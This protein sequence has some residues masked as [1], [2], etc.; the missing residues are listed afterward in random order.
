MNTEPEEAVSYEGS[1][2][3]AGG[4]LRGIAASGAKRGQE[5]LGEHDGVGGEQTGGAAHAASPQALAALERRLRE[6]SRED[7]AAPGLGHPVDSTSVP[8]VAQRLEAEARDARHRVQ[9]RGPP[10]V[11][12]DRLAAKLRVPGEGANPHAGGCDARAARDERSEVYP[13]QG[14][15]FAPGQA[16]G[17]DDACRAERAVSRSENAEA[18]AELGRWVGRGV[19]VNGGGGLVLALHEPG[20]G[21]GTVEQVNANGRLPY[22]NVRIKILGGGRRYPGM[23]RSFV[24]GEKQA[25]CADSMLRA[26]HE[27]TAKLAR[28]LGRE[29]KKLHKENM[30]VETETLRLE[31]RW[32]PRFDSEVRSHVKQARLDIDSAIFGK[33]AQL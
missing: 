22:A 31:E 5:L 29:V 17:Q 1:V 21:V 8:G 3:G 9:G 23:K 19:E 26:V 25:M 11:R 32:Q 12:H 13:Q 30:E 7:G 28:E 20:T 15:S 4:H 16:G 14:A 33:L 2:P 27:A 10:R 6:A 18:C 24:V